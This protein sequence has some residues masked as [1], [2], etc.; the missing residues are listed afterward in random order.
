MA[1]LKI[2]RSAHYPWVLALLIS[3]HV[4]GF[5][6]LQ[7]SLA[8]P[9]FEALVP[10]NLLVGAIVIIYFQVEYNPAFF[11]FMGIAYAVGF[12]AEWLGVNTKLIFGDYYY[13]Q[14]LGVKWGGV[15]LIIG[16]NW[17]VLISVTGIMAYQASKSLWIRIVIGASLMVLIDLLI[18]P[19]A[20]RHDFW[21]W[22][23]PSVPWQ[24][25]FAW[26]LISAFLLIIFYR[27]NFKKSNQMAWPMYVT[28]FVFFLAHNVTYL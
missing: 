9:Y 26:F 19:V 2:D 8:R 10:F 21:Q 11:W 12:A 5:I 3:M 18:E 7:S 14:T 27:L 20:I 24:N 13:E 22:N 25:Y 15:P 28:Q 6:G 16:L 1:E 17:F 23:H 4:A